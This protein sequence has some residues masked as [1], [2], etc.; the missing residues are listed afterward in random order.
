MQKIVIHRPGGYERLG[1]ETHS[2]LVP[3]PGDVLVAVDAIGV[4]YADCATRM[5]LYASAKHYEGYPITPGFEVAGRVS[6]TG[7]GVEDLDMGTPV[8]AITRFNAYASQVVVTRDQVFGIPE[9]L[10]MCQAAGFSAVGLTAWFALFELAHPRRGENLLVHSAA[11]GVGSALVQLAKLAGCRVIGVVGTSHKVATVRELGADEIIDKSTQDLWRTA[12]DLSPDG[13]DIIL[14]ANGIPTLGAS[15]RHLASLGRLVVYGFHGMLPRTGGRP[16]RLRLAWNYLRTP[17]FNPFSMTTRNRSVLAFNLSFLF[18]R[19]SIFQ[20]GMQQLLNWVV[21]GRI[22]PPPI[23]AYPF[24]KVADAHRDLESG[25]TIG[26][27]V[28]TL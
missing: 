28:L 11:G 26:K 18:A 25:Q 3:G 4:N 2:D 20:E 8:I 10:S 1:I 27:L 15:Y 13:Y 16:N 24:A 7:E 17:C 14:D 6:A 5:G 19:K 21:S 22:H 9:G 23:T 12:L